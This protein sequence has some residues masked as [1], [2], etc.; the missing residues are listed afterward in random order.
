MKHPSKQHVENMLRDLARILAGPRREECVYEVLFALL[1]PREREEI[2]LRWELVGLLALG[3]PQRA[4]AARLGVSL[5]KITRGAREMK[6]GP[7]AFRRMVRQAVMAARAC[8]TT[9]R[10]RAGRPPR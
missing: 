3:L 5:C 8:S 6:Y 4:I 2:A 1:T 10:R 9:E 7:P